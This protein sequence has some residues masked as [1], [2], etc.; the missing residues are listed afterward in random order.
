MWVDSGR[1]Y[2]NKLKQRSKESSLFV[3]LFFNIH[4]NF[5]EKWKRCS[6]KAELSFKDDCGYLIHLVPVST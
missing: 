2:E 3:D 4:L 6:T 5:S 1:N